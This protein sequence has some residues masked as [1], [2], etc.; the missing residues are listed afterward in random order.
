MKSDRPRLSLAHLPPSARELIDVIGLQATLKLVEARGGRVLP[1]PKGKRRAGV[2]Q[3]DELAEIV[4]LDAAKRLSRR[5]GGAPLSIPL[6][7]SAVRAARDEALQ[8]RFDHLSAKMSARAAVGQLVGEF[9]P[10]S[11]STVWRILKRP[12]GGAAIAAL[13]GDERQLS[14]F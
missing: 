8:A 9:G 7:T 6:C 3:L 10:I 12:A 5:Y 11:E 13:V 2:A 14:M 4:G 1:I